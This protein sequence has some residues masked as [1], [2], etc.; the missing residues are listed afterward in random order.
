MKAVILRAGREKSLL[1]RHPWIFSGAIAYL[2][3]FENGDFLPV[4][5]SEKKFLGYAYFNKKSNIIG[6]IVSFDKTEPLTAIRRNMEKAIELRNGWFAGSDT[7]AYRLI[8]G[9]G[10]GIPGLVVDHYNGT[11]VLQL[12][13]LGTDRL[14]SW[15]VEQLIELCQPRTIFEKSRLPARQEEGLND[16]VGL[17][18][19]EEAQNVEIR[20]NGHRFFAA[21]LE[22]QKTGFFLD[23]REMRLLVQQFAKDKRVLNCFSYSG[24]FSVYA[25]KGGAR[26]IK[27]VDCSKQAMEFAKQNMEL[28][29]IKTEQEYIVDDVFMYLQN[30]AIEE[31]LVILDPPALAKKRGDLKGAYRGYLH[32]NRLA[33]EKMPPKSYL[34]TCSCSYHMDEETFQKII[35][36]A[37]QASKRSVRILS[38]HRLGT[39]HPIN[40]FH[41]EGDYLKSLFLQVD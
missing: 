31:N 29:G 35:F 19:G 28:N 20:E 22:G 33:L 12:T 17:L 11:L 13:T 10:D 36:K 24:G 40:L 16:Q 23:T 41:P 26:S 6:R 7:N 5:S 30:H 27:N 37:A 8:N 34:L 1:Q 4:V 39:D 14:R 25:A 38:R 3:P 2:P 21:I 32:L 9:E 18:W 15:I